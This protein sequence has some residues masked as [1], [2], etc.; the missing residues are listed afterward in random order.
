M[1]IT[2]STS[3]TRATAKA[4]RWRRW[5]GSGKSRSLSSVVP[6]NAG[7]HTPRPLCFE[8]YQLPCSV[9]RND[10]LWL[11]VPAF[12]GTT[13]APS[14]RLRHPAEDAV[15]QT[16]R[17]SARR[18]RFLV[19]VDAALVKI[20]QEFDVVRLGDRKALLADKHGVGVE[21]RSDEG[22]RGLRGGV[23][24]NDETCGLQAMRD[25]GLLD[26]GQL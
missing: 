3:R 8:R 24:G 23:L 22:H 11:W 19:R 10:H 13:A 12:A 9:H 14:N 18:R 6:A 5:Q 1:R 4:A 17:A 15:D 16:G 21:E 25:H 2:G 26:G 7:T 20:F